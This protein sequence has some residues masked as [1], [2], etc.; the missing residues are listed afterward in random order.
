[1]TGLPNFEP[2]YAL[3]F[4][5]PPGHPLTLAGDRWL[6]RGVSDL[7]LPLGM[8]DA[9]SHPSLIEEPRRYGFHATL[10][11]PFRLKPGTSR[12]ELILA[13]E[14]FVRSQWPCPVGLLRIAKLGNT[15][16]LKPRCPTP[17]ARSFASRVVS[18]F[19]RFRAPLD[20]WELNRRLQ[21]ALDDVETTHLVMWGYPYVFERYDFHMTL[22]GPVEPREH[23]TVQRCLEAVFG[24]ALD[25]DFAIDSI[26]L[27][28]QENPDSDFVAVRRFP[29]NAPP[30]EVSNRSRLSRHSV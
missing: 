4:T 26:T 8:R 25:D 11:A 2:R 7:C 27:C 18:A 19:D 5:P 12:P 23:G 20:S 17:F 9:K 3:Y 1:M 6:R 15:F 21:P 30:V 13:I 28:E 29:F 10:K 22:T 14:E 24:S 16:A